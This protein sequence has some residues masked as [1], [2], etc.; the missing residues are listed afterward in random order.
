[1]QFHGLGPSG[2]EASVVGLGTWAI[3][4]WMWGGTDEPNAVEAIQAAIDHGVSLI[5]TAP[6]YGFGLSE[7]LVGRAIAD[8]RD[9]VVLA[10]K[11]GLV[12]DRQEG[13]FFMHSDDRGVTSR[14]SEKAIY[15]CLRPASIRQEVEQSLRRLRT[16]RLD[17]LQT[18]WQDATTP[19]D[20][21][22]T[23]L[24]RLKREGKIRAI[25]VSNIGMDHL[26][27]YGPID[28]VQ[29]KYS[30]IDRDVENNGILDFCREH[31]LAILAY[32]PLS[33]GLLTGKLQPNRQYG[34][35]DLRRS[36]ARFQKENLERTN[37]ALA[38]LRPIAESHR[39]TLAQVIIAWTFSQPGITHVLCGARNAGQAIENAGAG[40][41]SLSADER[42]AIGR[43]GTQIAQDEQ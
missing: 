8:R 36:R 40:Q 43:V 26:K 33:N 31:G 10:T 27:A 32:S 28:T 12:W 29:E 15:R 7:E 20:E 38:A 25:G 39:A 2:I 30:L 24:L 21:T 4:G 11:C 34:E 9:K 6:V 5:D 22:M 14:P 37:A 23:M 35:G 1:M 17:L 41:I 3:G 42:A 18:H 19:I 13:Q 16:D